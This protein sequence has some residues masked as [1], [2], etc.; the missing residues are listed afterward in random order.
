MDEAVK[1][2]EL[3][4]SLGHPINFQCVRS[5]PKSHI[6][7]LLISARVSFPYDRLRIRVKRAGANIYAPRQ[8][9]TEN[10]CV[11]LVDIGKLKQIVLPKVMP[12]IN[13]YS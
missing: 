13:A 1:Y 4:K 5:F 8:C 9:L 11:A 6:F 3:L 7:Q 2:Y 10:P 12:V